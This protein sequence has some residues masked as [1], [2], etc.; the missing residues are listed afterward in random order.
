MAKMS[1]TTGMLAIESSLVSFLLELFF[2]L[3]LIVY[4]LAFIPRHYQNIV[5]E[6]PFV[7]S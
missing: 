2:H 5:I 1:W 6:N 7:C 3:S 4:F